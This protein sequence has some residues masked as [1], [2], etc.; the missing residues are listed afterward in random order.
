LNDTSSLFFIKNRATN[1]SIIETRI[2]IPLIF[3]DD[4]KTNPSN[5][6]LLTTFLTLFL[7][8][9]SILDTSNFQKQ[10]FFYETIL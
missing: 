2:G 6:S 9:C 7:P 8:T 10:L 4:F 1:L 3:F 5:P